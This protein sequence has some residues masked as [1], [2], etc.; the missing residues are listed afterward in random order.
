MFNAPTSRRNFLKT[1]ALLAAPL[2]LPARV[3][4]QETAPSKR[5]TLGCIG[6]GKQM[7]GHLNAFVNR[8]D[9]E[10]LAVCDVDTTRRE[11]AKKKVDDTYTAKAGGTYKGCDAYNDF[12]EVLARKDI[13]AVVI[14]TPDHWHA[15]IAIAA[16]KAGKDVYCEKPLTYSV[17]EAVELVKAVR[18]ANRVFQVG[19]Q[20]RSSREFRVACELVRNGVLG[21]VNSIHVS[22]GD[23]AAPYR[24]PE[25]ALEPGLDWKMWCG[26]GPL[27]PYNPMLSP[28]GIHDH[29]PKWRNT[30]EFGGGMITDW[31]AHH[32]DISQWALNM[33][34]NG[35]VEV[36]AP[37]NWET[38]KR[39]AQLVYADG[40]VLT[41]VKGKGVSFYGTEGE[42]HVNRGKFELIMGGKT[43]RKFWDK[44]VDKTTSMERE[45]ELTARE[46][47][48]NAKIKLYNSK[49][50]FQNFLDCVKSRERPIC[51]V[52]V[53]ASS[54]IACHVMNFAYR[55]GATAKWNPAKNKFASGGN[56]KWLTRE[57][58]TDG[59][60]V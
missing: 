9:V 15:Y 17:H 22:F 40:T 24:E 1:S 44:E 49:T 56:S 5:L 51:D 19:S 38:A 60:K 36:R 33:D 8:D 20:Q 27:V 45:V 39:G 52:E 43:V 12:R 31:G 58:Y 50:H 13:D 14:A 41:H 46:Y 35:P 32:I 18:K 30:W 11:A 2:I 28:R 23:P 16:V 54:V 57:R 7:R 47:L 34:G 48:A 21:R 53:G 42:L 10:V 59:W 55:Y 29:F 25:E 6:M 26:P 4:S 37:Q 3:W